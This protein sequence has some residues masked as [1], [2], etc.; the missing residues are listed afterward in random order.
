[1]PEESIEKRD[2]RRNT[3]VEEKEKSQQQQLTDDTHSSSFFS[4]T[5]TMSTR[6]TDVSSL[7]EQNAYLIRLIRRRYPDNRD[8]FNLQAFELQHNADFTLNMNYDEKSNFKVKM[9]CKRS[10]IISSSIYGN[11][12]QLS[13]C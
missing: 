2:E 3:A 12:L 7:T 13:N 4:L 1:V 5:P 11:E 8:H 9:K 6:V 10:K